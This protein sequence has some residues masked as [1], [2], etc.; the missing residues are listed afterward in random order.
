MSGEG[1]GAATLLAWG[2]PLV[3]YLVIIVAGALA[4]EVWRWSGVIM[5]R[6]IDVNSETFRLAKAVSTALIAGLISRLIFF[7]QGALADVGLSV[8]LA[9]F[10]AG[11]A[12]YVVTR[13]R[14]SHGMRISFSVAAGAAALWV[15]FQFQ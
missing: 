12:A 7:P 6:D 2:D 8:R 13:G 4:T 14:F 3:V 5:A 10:A 1:G 11:F 15:L 9:G